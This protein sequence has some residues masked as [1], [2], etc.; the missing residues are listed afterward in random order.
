V[1]GRVENGDLARR[2]GPSD[3]AG[4]LCFHADDRGF[5]VSCDEFWFTPIPRRDLY[6][7]LG[8]A[9]YIDGDLV[10][11]SGARI[12]ASHSML[13]TPDPAVRKC[14][15]GT[16]ATHNSWGLL[17]HSRM[18]I[19]VTSQHCQIRARFMPCPQESGRVGWRS[20][21]AVLQPVVSCER[22][23]SAP[24]LEL[25]RSTRVAK[26]LF[27][28]HSDRNAINCLALRECLCSL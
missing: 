5:A 13:P 9:S 4:P 7:T 3:A 15:S 16:T 27:S 23:E 19:Q 24:C 12:R 11:I 26:L 20:S 22:A 8:A 2:I 25:I 6:K 10:L 14:S 17:R 21:R 18:A 1:Y 28:L